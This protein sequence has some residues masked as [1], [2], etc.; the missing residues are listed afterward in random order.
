MGFIFRVKDI[1]MA[2]K[3]PIKTKFF[4]NYPILLTKQFNNTII[5]RFIIL[6]VFNGIQR[7][8]K[9]TKD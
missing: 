1:T 8:F 7:Q 9:F 2:L 5:S 3:R 6:E 4:Q